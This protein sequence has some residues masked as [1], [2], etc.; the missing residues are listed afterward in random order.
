M[1][2]PCHHVI[3][4]GRKSV[5]VAQDEWMEWMC[6]ETRVLHEIDILFAAWS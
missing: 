4:D 2:C 6:F 5:T 3:R 1:Y